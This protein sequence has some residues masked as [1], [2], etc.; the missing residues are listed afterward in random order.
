MG[1]PQLEHV[2]TPQLNGLE[3]LGT[4]QAIKVPN[5]VVQHTFEAWFTHNAVES[6]K[7]TACV[8]K[9]QASLRDSGKTGVV[10]DTGPV[11]AEGSNTARIATAAFTYRIDDINYNKAAD[12][13]GAAFSFVHVVTA[14][15]FG[16]INVYVDTAGALFTLSAQ[17]GQDQTVALSAASA[18][19]AIT[20]AEAIPVPANYCYIGNIIIEADAGNW[21]AQTDDLSTDLTSAT[22]IQDSI[23]YITIDTKTFNAA[24]LARQRT[25]FT[26]SN[27]Y[28]GY[29]RM[30]LSALTGT[31]KVYCQHVPIRWERS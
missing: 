9:L 8:I 14:N 25:M 11:M 24:D 26:L 13:V 4:S 23:P 12:T 7:I 17:L 5:R 28:P 31:G 1:I 20:S 16:V 10:T 2:Q 3:A 15:K 30:F 19:A 29:M 6:G 27:T 18:A 21:V 22:F